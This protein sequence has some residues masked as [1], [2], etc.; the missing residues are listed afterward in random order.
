MCGSRSSKGETCP[1]GLPLTLQ[2]DCFA[3]T[4]TTTF[5]PKR[6]PIL[7]AFTGSHDDYHRPTDTPDKLNYDG[8]A[9]VARL[10]AAIAADLAA[11]DAEPVWIESKSSERQGQR[12]A[13]RVYLGT[14]PDYSQG[15]IEGVRLSGVSPVGP[16]AKAGLRGGDVIV[17]LSG[18][19]IKNIYDYTF[20]LGELKI[21]TETSIDILR[22][23]RKQ[24]LKIT[25]VSRD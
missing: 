1:I 11:T 9:Q 21:D 24:S 16:A 2:S 25:P 8:A 4:D 6:V 10:M 7:N 17:A 15:D 5:Y 3:P 18:R 22:D 13:M 14:I 20:I 12:A 19:E 23:G